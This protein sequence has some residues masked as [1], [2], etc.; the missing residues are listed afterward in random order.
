VADLAD[1]ADLAALR[2][3]HARP[4]Q[5]RTRFTGERGREIG[6]ADR[7]AAPTGPPPYGGCSPATWSRRRQDADHREL[8]AAA[9]R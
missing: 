5:A 3:A 2:R 6:A 9:G 1:L 8:S 4:R 7:S